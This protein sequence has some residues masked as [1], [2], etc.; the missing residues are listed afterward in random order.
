MSKVILALLLVAI[1][2]A[3]SWGVYFL[4]SNVNQNIVVPA[5][6][7]GSTQ[8][9]PS[10]NSNQQNATMFEIQGMK[11]EVLQQGTG[12][13][14]QDGDKVTVHYTGTLADGTK[15]DSSVDRNAPFTFMLG[16]G[17]VIKGW[18]LGVME[19][20]VGDKRKLIIPP[21]LAY[22]AAGFLMIPPN[23]TLT[24]DIELLAISK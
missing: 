3:V 23:A 15:F 17:R 16:R 14:A 1:L 24:F 2:A 10:Q 6:Q 9:Q 5:N 22:G 13:T 4:L 19:M 21:D 12:A 11:V 7:T 8:N 18:D 20:K